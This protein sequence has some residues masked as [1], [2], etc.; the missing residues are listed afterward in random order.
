MSRIERLSL[1]QALPSRQR[2]MI[3]AL[4]AA[5]GLAQIDQP[6]P[7]E[8]ALQHIPTVIVLLAAP[9]L[10]SRWPLSD[11]SVASVLAFL[12]LH[13]LGGRYTYSNVPY[14]E[15]SRALLGRS[16]GETFGFARNNMIG[17]SISA[18]GCLPSRRSGRRSSATSGCSGASLSMSRWSS[19]WR[20]A[21][22]TRFSNG[23]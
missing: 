8:A 1:W 2:G 19:S 4:A 5:L 12:L 18:S 23:Y 9:W 14:D 7:G 16:V 20:A 10:L 15:W 22:S 17:W 13:T 3:V 11:G 21:A 6:Y